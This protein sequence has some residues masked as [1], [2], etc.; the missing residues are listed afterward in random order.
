MTIL[1]VEFSAQFARVLVF[2]SGAWTPFSK[3]P[4]MSRWWKLHK[5]APWQINGVRGRLVS[6][7]LL[8]SLNLTKQTPVSQLSCFSACTVQDWGGGGGGPKGAEK[9]ET[10]LNNMN[11]TINTGWVMMKS[12]KTSVKIYLFLSVILQCLQDPIKGWTW[13]T[14][15]SLC[16]QVSAACMPGT[17]YNK[18]F[19]FCPRQIKQSIFFFK[20]TSFSQRSRNSWLTI[21]TAVLGEA[22]GHSPVDGRSFISEHRS[23]KIKKTF[24]S[25]KLQLL[26]TCDQPNTMIM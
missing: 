25:S 17:N 2:V 13:K 11:N 26:F 9:W 18:Y 19:V 16:I 14:R 1:G 20:P 21:P 4:G 15:S 23:L 22:L 12:K 3:A 7:A 8:L 5:H 24:S 10:L 6:V